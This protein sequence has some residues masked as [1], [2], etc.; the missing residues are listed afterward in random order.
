MQLLQDPTNST[1]EISINQLLQILNGSALDPDLWP[2]LLGKP[3]SQFFCIQSYLLFTPSEINTLQFQ[4]DLS[5]MKT[6]SCLFS[7]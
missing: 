1:F 3:S 6:L 2:Q 4:T 5:K 7:D